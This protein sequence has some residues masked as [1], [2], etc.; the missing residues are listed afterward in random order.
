MI[1]RMADKVAVEGEAVGT[2]RTLPP[3]A[4]SYVLRV[5]RTKYPSMGPRNEADLR[6][7]ATALDHLVK[8]RH[9]S[10]ADVISQQIT[11]IGQSL[12][13][14]GSWEN[15]RF[16]QLIDLD[17]S[18]VGPEERAMLA[19]ERKRY[20]ALEVPWKGPKGAKDQ[21]KGKKNWDWS[22]NEWAQP[23]G[24]KG[25]VQ[26]NQWWNQQGQA[27]AKGGPFTQDKGKGQKGKK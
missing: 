5:M 12:G 20:Q 8:G 15:A 6:V 21:G 25:E 22:R 17:D 2:I 9:L 4:K 11:A 7:L 3:V 26:A 1:T 18:L 14:H 13:D 10:A 19:S 27:P 24:G 23:K 16:L